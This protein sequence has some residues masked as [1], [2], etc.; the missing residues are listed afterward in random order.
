M[1][2]KGCSCTC[3]TSYDIITEEKTE[4]IITQN[5]YI[6]S[7]SDQLIS[8]SSEQDGSNTSSPQ[9]VQTN[10]ISK[11]NELKLLYTKQTQSSNEQKQSFENV[12]Q[13]LEFDFK[14]Q[15]KFENNNIKNSNMPT[16]ANLNYKNTLP[17]IAEYEE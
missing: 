17:T 11:L 5:Q 2:E 14:Q 10:P 6:S 3:C 13:K 16:L 4:I 15:I 12:L 1:I 7:L 8:S 9:F